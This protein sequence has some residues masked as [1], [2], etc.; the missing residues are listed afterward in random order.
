MLCDVM[1]K[2]LISTNQLLLNEFKERFYF[3]MTA[4]LSGTPELSKSNLL[5]IKAL[6]WISISVDIVIVYI[7]AVLGYLQVQ[8]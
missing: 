6:V 8:G 4:G 2:A 7:F 5:I 3:K 1:S